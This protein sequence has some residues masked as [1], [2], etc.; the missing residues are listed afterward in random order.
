MDV[1]LGLGKRRSAATSPV[2][3]GSEAAREAQV[4]QKAAS[5]TY[6]TGLLIIRAWVED[7]SLEPLRADVRAATDVSAGL[8]RAGTLSRPE[9]VVATVQK[10]LAEVLAGTAPREASDYPL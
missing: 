8:D 4:G 6:T 2:R 7:G 1:P 9:D 3:A 5:T 10:W